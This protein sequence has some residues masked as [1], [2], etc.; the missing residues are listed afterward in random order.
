MSQLIFNPPGKD[1]PGYL[2]R[3]REALTFQAM[4]QEKP[5]VEALDAMIN[6]LLGYVSEP[7]DRDEARE[8]MLDAS[9]E[10]F[11]GMLNAVTGD[12]DE[13]PT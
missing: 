4:M 1:T 10:Q 6:F 3:A 5:T 7:E 9:E 2:R 12:V 13:N 8:L 11:L